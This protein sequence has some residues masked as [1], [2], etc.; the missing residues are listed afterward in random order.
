M[1]KLIEM[2]KRGWRVKANW[3]GKYYLQAEHNYYPDVIGKDEHLTAA[4]DYLFAQAMKH[5]H[6]NG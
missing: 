1:E 5:E 3:N 4:V 2:L 6:G